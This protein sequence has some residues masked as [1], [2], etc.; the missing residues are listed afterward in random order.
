MA[1][2]Y[3]LRLIVIDLIYMKKKFIEI[4]PELLIK[5]IMWSK[6][7]IKT[8]EFILFIINLENIRIISGKIG[9]VYLNSLLSTF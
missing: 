2:Y 3:R 8:V 9:K 6:K 4:I 7:S 1:N 5:Q